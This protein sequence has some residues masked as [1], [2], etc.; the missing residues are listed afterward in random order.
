MRQEEPMQLTRRLAVAAP[1]LTMLVLPSLGLPH[2]ARG[3]DTTKLLF[4]SKR[5][6][7]ADIYL[8][9]ADGS[10]AKNLTNNPAEDNAA[11]WSPDGAR[12]AFASDRSG[13]RD[14]WVMDAD[15]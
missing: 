10:D 5:G 1:L 7:N 14:I 2:A 3:A 15:G 4:T 8:A 9:N 11:C 12:I 6:G 13:N